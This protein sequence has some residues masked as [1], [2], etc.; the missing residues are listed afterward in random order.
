MSMGR[1]EVIFLDGRTM[2]YEDV[3]TVDVGHDF[4]SVINRNGVEFGIRASLIASFVYT[5]KAA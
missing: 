1:L 5:P 2:H 4:L 3:E